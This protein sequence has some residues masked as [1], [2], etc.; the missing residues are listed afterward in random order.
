[1]GFFVSAR[2]GSPYACRHS[3]RTLRRA[4]CVPALRVRRVVYAYHGRD[5]LPY[6]SPCLPDTVRKSLALGPCLPVFGSLSCTLHD[7]VRLPAMPVP[8]RYSKGSASLYCAMPRHLDSPASRFAYLRT[9]VYNHAYQALTQL[10]FTYLSHIFY[11]RLA[12]KLYAKVLT[13]GALRD[14]HPSRV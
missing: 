14:G 3:P 7:T 8:L 1:M 11:M 5:C 2:H 13:L 6:P 9:I 12:W 10:V 4:Y